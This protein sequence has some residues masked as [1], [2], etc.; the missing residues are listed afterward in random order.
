MV[1]IRVNASIPY[2]ITI[3]H[4]EDWL[5]RVPYFKCSSIWVITDETVDR[6]H[7]TAFRQRLETRQ[8]PIVWSV[9]RP[10]DGSKSLT[11]IER[12]VT[13]G[14][15]SHCDRDTLVIAFGGGMVGDLAGFLASVYMRGVRYIQ[16][17]TTILA[18]DSAVG[19][20]V[21]V[22]HPL[23][24]NAIGAFYQPAGVHY[25]VDR[26]ETLTDRDVL[27]GL[28]EL[29]KHAYLSRYVLG[30]SFE[31]DLFTALA[32]GPLE[33]EAW[34]V[35]GIEVKRRIVEADERE[36]GVRAW[37]NFG[38]TFGHALESVEAYRLTHGEAVLYGMVYA[39]LVG[40][41]VTR[42]KA[43]AGFL[44][45]LAITPIVW[46]PFETYLEVMGHDKKNRSG[47]IRFVL[48]G[49]DVTVASVTTERLVKA[50]EQLKGWF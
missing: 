16:V 38:H 42:A 35:R 17:P 30:H 36:Q 1:T 12:L 28:G 40:G 9:V 41:D 32:Q 34:L 15:T 22:N 4:G 13:D 18:H 21:A 26:L 24:K 46:Q 27:S 50:Y 19:G 2:D 29:I 14:L 7:G 45:Q 20:K 33:W 47:R 23:A 37:L 25:N 31:D 5:D 48:L 11:M 8:R 39:F 49:E 10:G 3:D 6:L 43:L 44:K